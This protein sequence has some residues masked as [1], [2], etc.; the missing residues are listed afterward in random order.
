M[1]P[2]VQHAR[3]ERAVLRAS[4]ITLK[5]LRRMNYNIA[6]NAN[7][8]DL[9][10]FCFCFP[11]I[12][13]LSI[14]SFCFQVHAVFSMELSRQRQSCKTLR[15]PVSTEIWWHLVLSGGAQRHPL[16]RHQIKQTKKK[17]FSSENRVQNLSR[18]QSHACALAPQLAWFFPW[19]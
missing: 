6:I 13:F 15:F 14:L 11:L 17:F 10:V 8:T 12:N 1:R 3:I 4:I 5:L 9:N 18:L 19:F 7:R 2:D 16:P